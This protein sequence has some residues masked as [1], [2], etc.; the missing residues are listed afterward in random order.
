M[1]WAGQRIVTAPLS[2]MAMPYQQYQNAAA[3]SRPLFP[4]GPGGN[5]EAGR[6]YRPPP[7]PPAAAAA[8]GCW[9]NTWLPPDESPVSSA[10][11]PPNQT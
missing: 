1:G 5:G 8:T 4:G 7:S 6:P 9:W 10:Q 11:V 2:T 3:L